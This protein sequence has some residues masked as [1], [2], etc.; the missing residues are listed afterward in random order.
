MTCFM[1]EKIWPWKVEGVGFIETLRVGSGGHK[2]HK[3]M[4]VT[5]YDIK[6]IKYHKYECCNLIL[7][8][9]YHIASKSAFTSGI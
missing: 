3:Y 9:K 6:R 8:C 4:F 5:T 2:R 7:E 1:R